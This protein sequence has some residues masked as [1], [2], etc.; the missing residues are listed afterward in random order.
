MIFRWVDAL[1]SLPHFQ[2][3]NYLTPMGVGAIVLWSFLACLVMGIVAMLSER[4]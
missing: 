4:I 3:I 1:R 2:K